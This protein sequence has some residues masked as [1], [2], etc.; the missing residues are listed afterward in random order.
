MFMNNFFGVLCTKNQKNS[1]VVLSEDLYKEIDGESL[2]SEYTR[3]IELI[4]K[5][6]QIVP[7]YEQELLDQDNNNK[8]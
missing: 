7:I 6:E 3:T 2:L 4:N 1:A 8:K 5:Y